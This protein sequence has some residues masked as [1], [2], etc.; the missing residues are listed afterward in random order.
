LQQALVWEATEVTKSGTVIPHQCVELERLLA[1]NIVPF[2][3]VF[4]PMVMSFLYHLM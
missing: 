1:Q 3:V 2:L 4:N